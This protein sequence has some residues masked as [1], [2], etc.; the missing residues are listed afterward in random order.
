MHDQSLE[1]PK[2]ISGAALAVT[3]RP[4]TFKD[5]IGHAAAISQILAMVASGIISHII[6][7]GQSGVGKT[8]LARLLAKLLNCVNTARLEPCRQCA[9]CQTMEEGGRHR[10]YHER[11][12]AGRDGSKEE[13]ADFLQ[14]DLGPL[15]AGYRYRV[16]F[17]DEAQHFS[18]YS[19]DLLL[20]PLEEQGSKT[21]FIFALIDADRLPEAFQARCR[22]VRL[23]PPTVEEKLLG[24]ERA[25][26]EEHI[27]ADLGALQL[28]AERSQNLRRALAGLLQVRDASEG[29]PSIT[30][31]LT[32][33]TLFHAESNGAIG[34]LSAALA[35]DMTAA[36]AAAGQLGPDA[37]ACFR[38]VQRL[39]LHVKKTI[40]GPH[41]MLP[42]RGDTLLYDGAAIGAL[43]APIARAAARVNQSVPTFYDTLLEHWAL[44]PPLTPEAFETHAIR[45]VDLCT[46]YWHNGDPVEALA[47][48]PRMGESYRS[49]KARRPRIRRRHSEA[50]SVPPE[51][52]VS[53]AQA[54]ATYE[55]ATYLIQAYGVTFNAALLLD[56]GAL[57]V[58]AQ[59]AG[60]AL[61]TGFGREFA[62]RFS[63]WAANAEP[64]GGLHR[65]SLLGQINGS[66]TGVM[67]FHLPERLREQAAHWME[68]WFARHARELGP[69]GRMPA[70]DFCPTTD[71]RNAVGRHWRLLRRHVWAG[72]D[73]SDDAQGIPLI[74]RLAVSERQRRPAG[75]I[76]GPRLHLSQS[77]SRKSRAQ[78]VQEGMAHVSAWRSGRWDQLFT[79]WELREHREREALRASRAHRLATFHARYIGTGDPMT[80]MLIAQLEREER[81]S[82]MVDPLDRPRTRHCWP[83][84]A[85]RD[86]PEEESNMRP[87]PLARAFAAARIQAADPD[88]PDEAR[89]AAAIDSLNTAFAALRS[90]VNPEEVGLGERARSALAEMKAR[91]SGNGIDVV[92]HASDI[93]AAVP[94]DFLHEAIVSVHLPNGDRGLLLQL[95]DSKRIR[96]CTPAERKRADER[97]RARLQQCT[98]TLA[99][100]LI[101][102]H[103][104]VNGLECEVSA[105]AQIGQ[106]DAMRDV[107]AFTLPFHVMWE[108]YDRV[109]GVHRSIR[110]MRETQRKQLILFRYAPDRGTLEIFQGASRLLR[111][112]EPLPAPES[113]LRS[114]AAD[115]DRRTMACDALAVGLSWT[116]RL[117]SG[118]SNISQRDRSVVTNIGPS[119]VTF[120]DPSIDP[121]ELVIGSGVAAALRYALTRM[122]GN[123]EIR[124]D[125]Y[126]HYIEK[127]VAT[128]CF[129]VAKA[130]HRDWGY[131]EERVRAN[132]ACLTVNDKALLLAL[133]RMEA[134]GAEAASLEVLLGAYPQLKFSA[135]GCDKFGYTYKAVDY[136]PLARVDNPDCLVGQAVEIR[137]RE[138]LLSLGFTEDKAIKILVSNDR[139]GVLLTH[140][141]GSRRVSGLFPASPAPSE[142][143]ERDAQM[144]ADSRTD[145]SP[146][147]VKACEIGDMMVL[148]T[149]G[150]LP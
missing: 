110:W 25:C 32:R 44:I 113:A 74:E 95:R 8:T 72:L 18:T 119:Q 12:A 80:S 100:G 144:V 88:Q 48:V 69:G 103:N 38:A 124:S 101:R 135:L 114:L 140:Q 45:F 79:G 70:L 65:L 13:V 3:R 98:I 105:P 89:C 143:H 118:G 139:T 137:A 104:Q 35:G 146:E 128:L 129:E 57:G 41:R 49:T 17:W 138:W 149:S 7:V 36:L 131:V 22:T 51:Q 28:I 142:P 29:Q 52:F 53:A 37:T 81:D 107:A 63:A 76:L 62:Q 85:H 4:Q 127:G 26:A 112:V 11:N 123:A 27:R 141:N 77:I 102:V 82:W 71:P 83:S 20:K 117:G 9:S 30:A 87:D 73:P 54:A 111:S 130:D 16:V 34:F 42:T 86:E 134:T 125:G 68:A 58:N 59:R 115:S 147:S 145:T 67:L 64:A 109:R 92:S 39:L 90:G 24:L 97:L 40:I 121:D 108:L 120:A 23:E 132:G 46:A 148:A 99:P 61:L 116:L 78:D 75:V 19:L 66:V 14:H 43:A 10:A 84:T 106:S 50:R 122:G 93:L 31:D 33:R 91:L 5:V 1:M 136:I 133:C 47:H 55:A 60:A 96:T 21:I 94:L 6:F 150:G 15:P 56:F 126:H 2:P